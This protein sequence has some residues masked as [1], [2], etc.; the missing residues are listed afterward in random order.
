MIMNLLS[1]TIVIKNE[2]FKKKKKNSY[3]LLGIP[4]V[5]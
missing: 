3:P 4:I 1:G 5:L 2:M